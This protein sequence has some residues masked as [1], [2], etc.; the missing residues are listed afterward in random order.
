MKAS[1]APIQ[2]QIK[3]GLPTSSQQPCTTRVDDDLRNSSSRQTTGTIFLSIDSMFVFDAVLDT[4]G[5]EEKGKKGLV[6]KWN[7]ISCDSER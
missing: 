6:K 5:E 4:L 3:G 1:P 2:F 7:S